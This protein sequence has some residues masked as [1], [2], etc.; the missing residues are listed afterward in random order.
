MRRVMVRVLPVPAPANTH[1]GPRGASTASRCS[2]SRPSA[3]RLS[4]L[5]ATGMVLIMAGGTDNSGAGIAGGHVL[6]RSGY[7]GGAHD[8][9][10]DVVWLLLPAQDR[11]QVGWDPLHR[12]RH[13][14][15]SGGSGV[16]AV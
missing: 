6:V 16:R 15:G 7:G 9:H 4:R 12:G 11:A 2:S 1:S 13:R 3:M 8:V 10:H 14:A 5:L